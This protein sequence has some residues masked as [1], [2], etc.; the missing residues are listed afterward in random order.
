MLLITE[1]AYV[2]IHQQPR[3]RKTFGWAGRLL[4]DVERWTLNV[5]YLNLPSSRVARVCLFISYVVEIFFSSLTFALFQFSRDE[6][7]WYMVMTCYGVQDFTLSLVFWFWGVESVE[8]L[9]SVDW[10]SGVCGRWGGAS[11]NWGCWL[12][13]SWHFF[14]FFRAIIRVFFF[15]FVW[16]LVR[17]RVST[18]YY[19]LFLRH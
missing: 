14:F 5:E 10:F 7:W 19:C 15:S 13:Y 3:C 1:L 6:L 17:E 11:R 8:G 2:P 12:I 4:L 16:G 18:N 9:N